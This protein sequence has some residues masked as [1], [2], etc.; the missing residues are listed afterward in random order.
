MIKEKC[1]CVP[2][3]PYTD[4]IYEEQEIIPELSLE[5]LNGN[6]VQLRKLVFLLTKL[7]YPLKAA[8]VYYFS[9]EADEYIFCGSEPIDQNI[10]VSITD[11]NNSITLR[12]HCFIDE[13]FIK[14]I[15]FNPTVL[16]K[17]EDEVKTGRRT[18]ERKIGQVI[19]KVSTWRRL[20]NGYYD[21]NKKFIKYSLED[22]PV[23]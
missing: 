6:Q 13:D 17:E 22:A 7:G 18:K 2:I 11:E 10:Y 9:K 15:G 5:V 4:K 19:E 20:Y 8:L 12:C 14:T 23:S 1:L 16:K 3:N 21:E